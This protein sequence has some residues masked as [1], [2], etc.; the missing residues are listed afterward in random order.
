MKTEKMDLKLSSFFKM[1]S[2]LALGLLL[3]VIGTAQIG[4]PH[5]DCTN[6]CTANDVQ[7]KSAYLVEPNAPY[8]PLTGS[9]QCQG[10][11]SV[12]L[13]LDLTT[14]TPRVGVYVYAKIVNH[15]TPSIIYATVSECFSTALASGGV[16]KVVF[17]TPVSWPCGTAIDLSN[18]FIGWGTGGS[19]FCAGSPNPR[20][21]ATPSKCFSLPPGS[22]ITIVV[23]TS[24]NA[25]ISQCETTA[26]GGT[27]SFN[28]TS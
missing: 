18:V 22:Y 3:G 17:S 2:S 20:C 25:A 11:A 26:G 9:F 7:I 27:A 5:T 21:P 8:N 28:L 1:S 4:D 24:A 23:P 15:V 13:A 6:G 16:T 10:S 19:D 14:K 12:K